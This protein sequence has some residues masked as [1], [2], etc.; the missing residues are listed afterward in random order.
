[1]GDIAELQE[2]FTDATQ[3]R[4]ALDSWQ[5]GGAQVGI[6]LL[7]DTPLEAIAE[8]ADSCDVIQAMGI[9]VIGAQ[10][11]VFDPRVIA[12]IGQLH[13]AY[14]KACI[15]VDGGVSHTNIADLVRFGARKF[16]VGTAIMKQPDP[17]HAYNTLMTQAKIALR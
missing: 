17:A 16:L 7:M 12:K 6:A 15:A 10:G 14:P 8:V 2:A 11:A 5:S 4:E 9:D 1:M 13:M 3:A